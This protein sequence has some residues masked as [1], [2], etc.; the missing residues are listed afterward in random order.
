MKTAISI[1]DPVFNSAEIIAKK[2]NISRSEL[3]TKAVSE[4]LSKHQKSHIT[5]ALNEVYS[6]ENSSLDSAFYNSQLSSIGS[7]SW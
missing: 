5:E 2:L 3:Y 4:Y 7:E 6:H 1:P